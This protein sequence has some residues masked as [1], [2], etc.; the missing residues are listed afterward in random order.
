MTVGHHLWLWMWFMFGMMIYVLKRAYYLVTGPS[1][2]ANSYS[3]FFQVCWIP[4]LVRCVVD[5]GVY[6]ITF[7]P[8]LLNGVV[9]A[10]GIDY[11]L[12]SAIPQFG[13]VALF[14]GLFVDSIVDFAVTK[15][16]FVKDWL[17]QIPPPLKKNFVRIPE[18][19][20]N[21][22]PTSPESA[23]GD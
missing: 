21:N 22:A 13:V 7:Y 2:V 10:F 4:L 11:P 20:T 19:V 5:S 14:A 15:I 8:D 16:P 9:K 17:P 1:P 18:N 3:E 12:H 6:W 23:K